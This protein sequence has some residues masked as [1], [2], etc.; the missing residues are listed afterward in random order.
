[1]LSIQYILPTLG[2]VGNIILFFNSISFQDLLIIKH[3][4]VVFVQFIHIIIDIHICSF[5]PKF[6]T[7][8]R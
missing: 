1:M 6:M 8:C 7:K 2:N 5:R 4:S 3:L